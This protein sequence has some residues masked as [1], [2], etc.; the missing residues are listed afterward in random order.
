M[1][2]WTFAAES[3]VFRRSRV[4]AAAEKDTSWLAFLV[5]GQGAALLRL[6]EY[7]CL[8]MNE[9]QVFAQVGAQVMG[10]RIPAQSL[11]SR[12]VLWHCVPHGCLCSNAARFEEWPDLPQLSIPPSVGSAIAHGRDAQG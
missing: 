12:K 11:V 8:R 9:T 10:P 7:T 4:A 2:T 3:R 6:H 5:F 1:R